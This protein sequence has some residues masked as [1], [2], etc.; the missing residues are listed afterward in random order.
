MMI[1]D[2]WPKIGDSELYIRKLRANLLEAYRPD[3]N[4]QFLV[5]CLKRQSRINTK[6]LD[7]KRIDIIKLS[8]EY[9]TFLSTFQDKLSDLTYYP[10]GDFVDLS[11][12]LKAFR[13]FYQIF[14]NNALV[15]IRLNDTKSLIGDI[16]SLVKQMNDLSLR[17]G[18]SFN[19][20][21]K[22]LV[23]LGSA[24][25]NFQSYYKRIKNKICETDED[26]REWITKLEEKS[27]RINKVRIDIVRNI[28]KLENIGTDERKFL[29]YIGYIGGDGTEN[30]KPLQRN[31]VCSVAPKL[32]KMD[33]N[34]INKMIKV[35]NDK[36]VL[37]SEL[38]EKAPEIAPFFEMLGNI[39]NIISY[40]L[41][42]RNFIS[43]STSSVADINV[44]VDIIK[45]K[46]SELE[47]SIDKDSSTL[48]IHYLERTKQ[49]WDDTIKQV[50]SLSENAVRNKMK[51]IVLKNGG[52]LNSVSYVEET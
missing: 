14:Y 8:D 51:D 36:C 22:N 15:A 47:N 28:S 31:D 46:V 49:V 27:K 4:Y 7:K 23:W 20:L 5:E 17:L 33:Q 37:Y 10:Q 11:S 44:Q 13:D 12:S 52:P 25:T 29:L 18:L 2:D 26:M 32:E 16:S 45:K 3:R 21:S 50:L 43:N 9:N 30:M 48:L 24:T 38:D 39:E 6:S 42:V 1:E 35:L 40:V 34:L 19:E 41:K